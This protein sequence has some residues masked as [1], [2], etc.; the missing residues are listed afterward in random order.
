MVFG[1]KQGDSRVQKLLEILELK[2]SIDEDGDFKVSFKLDGDRS[3]LAFINSNT[4]KINDFEIREIWSV[5]HISEGF[6]DASIANY[7]L[8]ANNNLKIGSWRLKEIGENSFAV[9]FCIQVSANSDPESFLDALY[10]TLH[11]ADEMELKL[12]GKDKM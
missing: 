11:I 4:E 3:Q 12:T 8:L 9:T 6:L 1:R 7:L 5:A 2:Y 10:M